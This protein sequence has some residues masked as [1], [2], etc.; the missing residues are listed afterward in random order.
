MSTW[1]KYSLADGMFTGVTVT[2]SGDYLDMNIEPEC[3]CILGE[4]DALSQRI[5]LVTGLVIDYQPEQPSPDH[6]WDADTKRWLYVPTLADHKASKLA[7]INSQCTSTLGQITASYPADEMQ[8]WSKQEQEARAGG[9]PLIEA[10][11]AARGV[12]LAD[13]I[14][15]IIAKADAFAVASGQTIGNRQRC[16]DEIKAAQTTEE[17]EAITW[18]A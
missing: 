8:S 1:S 11:S 6:A 12:T 10:L 14:G 13:L 17:V 3:S 7:L 16:E 15:R 4:Y 9:G 2:C 18:T 5:D